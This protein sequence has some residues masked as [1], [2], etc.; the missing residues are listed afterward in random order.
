MIVV[1]A[2]GVG[3][4]RFVQGLI[5]VLPQR[6]IT[7]ISN[8]GDDAEFFGLHVSPDIDIVLY[9][10]AGLVD[11]AKGWGVQDDSFHALESLRRLGEETW[12]SLGDRDLA[13]SLY[14]TRR[15][16]A[17]EPLSAITADIARALDLEVRLL[18]MSDD[19]VATLIDSDDGTL[20]FQEYFV[21]RRAEVEVRAVRYDGVERARPAAGVLEAITEADG[22]IFA[23][24]NP[25]LSIGPILAVPGVR[26][27]LQVTRAPILAVS[28]IVAGDAI[29]GP[30]ARMLR[31]MGHE[32]S[33]RGVAALYQGCVDIFVVDQ[34]DAALADSIRGLVSAVVVADTIMR[35]PPEKTAL[36]RLVLDALMSEIRLKERS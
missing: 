12:F 29:K 16:R 8:T 2:G 17:G 6:E 25:F 27:A 7:V 24:S 35:G 33:A 15:L 9:T 13:M 14:R 1:L 18:P 31:S 30:A 36:A 28:P 23:P 11:E 10:L 21:K 32:V 34:V 19:R 22:V 26:H 4:A 20:P 5:G 3:A